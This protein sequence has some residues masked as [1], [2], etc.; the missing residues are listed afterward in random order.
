MAGVEVA[1]Q[2]VTRVGGQPDI[3]KGLKNWPRGMTF[4]LLAIG[5]AE[6]V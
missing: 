5:S 1:W 6:R 3:G 2:V 4:V